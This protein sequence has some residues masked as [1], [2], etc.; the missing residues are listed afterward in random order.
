MK[1]HQQRY[2]L[3]LGGIAAFL[4][5]AYWLAFSKTWVAYN[6]TTTLEQ[7]LSSASQAWQ[8]IEAYQQQ[9]EQLEAQQNNQSFT[10]NYFF[11][12]VT[13]FCQEHELTI[14]AMPESVIYEEEEAD[15]LLNPLQVEG[16]FI[17]MIRLLYHLEQQQQ[18]GSVVSVTFN[19]GK[20]Y[21]SRQQ[22][23]TASIFLQNIQNKANQ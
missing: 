3:L 19:L 13:A 22:E 9:M 6:K 20:N 16:Q 12:K 23:L 2:Q 14:Q 10:Q 11:Q 17:P 18:L 21:Q 4:V 5:V 1:N 15:V 8:E 7:Q